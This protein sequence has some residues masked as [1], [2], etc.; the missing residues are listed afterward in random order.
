MRPSTEIAFWPHKTNM[1]Q[2]KDEPKQIRCSKETFRM[3]RLNLRSRGQFRELTCPMAKKKTP[4][5]AW[6]AQACLAK[7]PNTHD[8]RTVL[9]VCFLFPAQDM[10]QLGCPLACGKLG[11]QCLVNC[12]DDA[13]LSSSLPLETNAKGSVFLEDT[14][15][16]VVQRETK[17]NTT[18]LEGPLKKD[19]PKNKQ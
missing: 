16:C 18:M 6:M 13:L 2:N 3:R 9:V 19:T 14:P 12:S 11:H 10:V 5:G 1:T 15:L 17:R 4:D 7:C 8:P